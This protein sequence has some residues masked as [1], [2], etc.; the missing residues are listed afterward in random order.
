M[1][2]QK[3]IIALVLFAVMLFS[4]AACSKNDPQHR[5]YHGPQHHPCR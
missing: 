5:Q 2:T 3:R 1:K 4:L